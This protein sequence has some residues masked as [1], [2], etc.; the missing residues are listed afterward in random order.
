[1]SIKKGNR[2]RC[3]RDYNFIDFTVMG[4]C[5]NWAR[6]RMASQR[7]FGKTLPNWPKEGS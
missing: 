2:R 5:F 7:F 3:R 6:I 4:F 1:M